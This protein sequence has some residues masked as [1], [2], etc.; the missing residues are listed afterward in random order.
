MDKRVN[1]RSLTFRQRKY[2]LIVEH[3]AF[4]RFTSVRTNYRQATRHGVGMGKEEEGGGEGTTR[5]VCYLKRHLLSL[6]SA[7]SPPWQ[8]NRTA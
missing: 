2:S 4:A 1:R 6:I 5:I 8:F 3:E 7:D